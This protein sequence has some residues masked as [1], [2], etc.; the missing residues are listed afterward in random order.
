LQRKIT[1]QQLENIQIDYGMLY[2]DYGLAGERRVGPTKGGAT[3]TATA[4]LRDIEFDGRKGKTKGLVVVDEINAMLAIANM[5][6]SMDEL[7]F[8]MPWA[9]YTNSIVT[10]KSANVGMVPSVSFVT[11]V[12]MFAKVVG[13]GYKKITLYNAMNTSVFT[14]AAVPK[15]EGT[16]GLEI[17][18]HWDPEDDTADLFKVEDVLTLGSDVVAP[19]VVTV[20]ADA[21][22]DIVVTSNLTATFNEDIKQADINSNNFLLIK[23]SDGSIVAGSLTYT[24]GTKT[25]AFDPTNSLDAST[26]YIWAISNVRDSAGN[27]MVPITVNFTTAA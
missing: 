13:G 25:A 7:A 19:T 1:Q 4:T 26:A 22:T 27:K 11:N 24:L 15:G 20:P 18:A 6:M 8:A 16:V 21:A 12:V 17:S 9:N 5:D 2:V 3:F 14:L 23:V 10:A